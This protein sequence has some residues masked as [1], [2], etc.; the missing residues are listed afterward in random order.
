M[1]PEEKLEIQDGP[2][3]LNRNQVAAI[4]GVSRRTIYN[5]VSKGKFPAPISIFGMARWEEKTVLEFIEKA[6]RQGRSFGRT[7]TAVAK[8][9]GA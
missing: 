2:R 1:T 8:E 5:A 4:L 6:K 7:K 9:E 3:L